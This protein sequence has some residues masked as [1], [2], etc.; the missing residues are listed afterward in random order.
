MSEGEKSEIISV[1]ERFVLFFFIF[2][3]KGE[4]NLS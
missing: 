2:F 4:F 3:K 1:S